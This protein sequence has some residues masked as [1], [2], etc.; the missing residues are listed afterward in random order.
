MTELISQNDLAAR[1]NAEHEEVKKALRNA[2]DHAMKTGKLLLQMK[3]TIPH[4]GWLEWVGANC[5][6]S[7][8]TAQV[9]MWLA[10]NWAL[11]AANTQNIADLTLIDAIKLL[12]QLKSPEE[13]PAKLGNRRPKTKT[14]PVADAIKSDPLAILQR[15]WEAT[16]Q[17]ERD[18]FLK[19]IEKDISPHP[20]PVNGPALGR[21]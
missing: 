5:R 4:G 16:E 9:Y 12:E 6:F 15:A 7:D 17:P 19:R 11:L 18:I 14:N 21:M 13:K 2:A 10:D 20:P 1:I 8:R 3:A